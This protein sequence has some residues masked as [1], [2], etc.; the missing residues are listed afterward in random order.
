MGTRVWWGWELVG[1]VEGT[2]TWDRVDG[3]QGKREGRKG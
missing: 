3:N 1:V 2:L